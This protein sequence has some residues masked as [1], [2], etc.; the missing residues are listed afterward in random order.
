MDTIL[1][2]INPEYTERILDG[3]KKYEFRK[4]IANKPVNKILMY[5]TAPTM[6]VVGEVQVIETIS[7][8][9]T[10]LWELAKKFAGISHD[11]YKDY[12]KGCKIAYA[13]KLGEVTKYEQPKEL[14]EFSI[15]Q[16]PRSFVYIS[17]GQSSEVVVEAPVRRSQTIIADSI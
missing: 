5:S 11:M 13:Y 2:S 16:A 1:L 9:P 15:Y 17:E 6:Q 7:T 8:S 14:V 10:A 12:F 3:T 4:R